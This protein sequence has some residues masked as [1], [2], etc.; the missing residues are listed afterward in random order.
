MSVSLWVSPLSSRIA[1]MISLSDTTIKDKANFNRQWR[2]DSPIPCRS[3]GVR[4]TFSY[5]YN[6]QN[7]HAIFYITVWGDTYIQLGNLLSHWDS[8]WSATHWVLLAYHCCYLHLKLDT[9]PNQHPPQP[10]RILI[11]NSHK[12]VTN[13]LSNCSDTYRLTGSRCVRLGNTSRGL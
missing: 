3:T 13:T 4:Y 2:T 6:L 9:G 12:Q 11:Y 10:Q 5:F 7:E 8:P 1:E